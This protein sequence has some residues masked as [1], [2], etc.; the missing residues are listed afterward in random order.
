MG[1]DFE[2]AINLLTLEV[3]DGSAP[4]KVLRHALKWLAD[5]KEEL[6]QQW[7]MLHG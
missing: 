5:N 2:V 6:I 1:P 4:V 7:Q 3:I